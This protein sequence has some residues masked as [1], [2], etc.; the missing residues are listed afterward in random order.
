[1]AELTPEELRELRRLHIQ[2]GRKV[3]SMFAGDY[4]SAVRGQGM[5]FEEVRTYAP[6]DD[7]RHI[8]WNVTARTGEPFV[9]QFRE[10]RQLTVIL[11]VDVS[12]S[13]RVGSGGRDGRTDRHLQMAR[14]A[15]GLAFASLRN[16]DRVG[17]ITFSDQIETYLPPRR[18]RGHTWAVIQAVFEAR[19]AHHGTRIEAPLEFINRT[20]RR[21]A[22]VIMVSDFLDST[23]WTRSMGAVARRHKTHAIMVTDRI[24][25]GLASLGLIETIDAETGRLSLVDARAWQIDLPESARRQRLI[26]A[27]I[28]PLSVSTDQDPYIAMHQHFHQIGARR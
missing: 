19:A 6:G 26:S 8:D 24:E 28:I 3:D 18:S 27:G 7:I 12:G 14:I 23:D 4:R 11:A 13:S 5:E 10:E 22:V 16:R 15:G 2:A 9:K 17:L 25:A 21:R 1:M 20:I